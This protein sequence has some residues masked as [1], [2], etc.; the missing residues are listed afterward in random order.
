MHGDIL[1]KSGESNSS[2]IVLREC[3]DGCPRL[4]V[5][6]ARRMRWS[7]VRAVIEG[8]E[9]VECTRDRNFAD[10]GAEMG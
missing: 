6:A 2:R 5:T 8:P 9:D 1:G 3:Q 7:M 10:L 4:P